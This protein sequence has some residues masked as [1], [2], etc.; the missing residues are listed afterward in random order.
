MAA[1][2]PERADPQPPT[3]AGV[4]VGS[5]SGSRVN[6][7]AQIATKPRPT[8]VT[9]GTRPTPARGGT[10]P[11]PARGGSRPTA[12]LHRGV[13]PQTPTPL[14]RGV[15]QLAETR[16]P[17]VRNVRVREAAS[18][19]TSSPAF[20][21]DLGFPTSPAAGH[22]VGGDAM[23]VDSAADQ[24]SISRGGKRK[25]TEGVDDLADATEG[26]SRK[27]TKT[28]AVG[29]QKE[30]RK[31]VP[32]SKRAGSASNKLSG[33]AVSSSK[34]FLERS[35]MDGQGEVVDTETHADIP[36]VPEGA[37]KYVENALV[38]CSWVEGD[39]SWGNLVQ[40]WLRFDEAAEFK[41]SSK[42][43]GRLPTSGRPSEVGTWISHAR[44]ATFRPE[45]V[46]PRFADEFALWWKGMQPEGRDTLEEGF[47]GLARGDSIDWT[48]LRI[49][50]PNGM[51]NVVGAL[52]WWHKAVYAL[53]KENATKTGRSGQK[54]ELE[55]KKLKEAL[56]DVLYVLGQLAI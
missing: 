49:S 26:P 10:R 45:V 17:S 39:A 30:P 27:K 20:R 43:L 2:G 24:S 41:P 40:G 21:Y 37:P 12:P 15:T 14:P 29:S 50:G 44:S 48:Q 42:Q 19:P 35:K 34:N 54:R 28:K 52:A 8:P 55:L 38:L 36:A 9:R 53:P 51:V 47:I 16:I 7:Q 3:L 33:A 32:M 31:T 18:E 22:T 1:S 11:T 23:A 25:N 56:N 46:L 4:P 5:G 6:A 13:T